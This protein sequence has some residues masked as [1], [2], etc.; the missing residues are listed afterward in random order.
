MIKIMGNPIA[1]QLS[2]DFG[3]TPEQ[4]CIMC[5][6]SSNC[7]KC[8][9][10]CVSKGTQCDNSMQEC[11]QTD[12]EYQ[13]ARWETWLHLVAVHYPEL[14]KYIP[15]KYHKKLELQLNI[16]NRKMKITCGKEAR[17]DNTRF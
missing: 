14:K 4:A 3:V 5:H 6:L 8:C 7:N 16:Y 10:Q 1:F 2:F 12:L 9:K 15:K 13:G 17:N 11:S